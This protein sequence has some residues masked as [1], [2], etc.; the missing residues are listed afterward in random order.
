MEC[1]PC[2]PGETRFNPFFRRYRSLGRLKDALKV[3]G[4]VAL[5]V[6]LRDG[7]V[8]APPGQTVGLSGAAGP[9]QIRAPW[10]SQGRCRQPGHAAPLQPMMPTHRAE[11]NRRPR[12]PGSFGGH[13]D[14]LLLPLICLPWDLLPCLLC[15]SPPLPVTL[16]RWAGSCG[17]IAPPPYPIPPGSRSQHSSVCRLSL[18]TQG[19]ALPS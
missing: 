11:G 16:V 2:I 10:L 19:T 3:T 6:R 12:A 5:P 7:R 4:S 14:L 13:R 18:A 8:L 9:Q 1:H 15:S 17:Y